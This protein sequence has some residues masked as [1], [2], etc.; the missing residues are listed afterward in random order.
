MNYNKV[1]EKMNH[2]EESFSSISTIKEL[3]DDVDRMIDSED[4]EKAK[5]SATVLKGYLEIF[6]RKWDKAFRSAWNDVVIPCKIE[7]LTSYSELNYSEIA[8]ALEEEKR[9]DETCGTL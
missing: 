2:L 4:L 6:T 7:D 5:E 1:W 3:V 8:D 9:L